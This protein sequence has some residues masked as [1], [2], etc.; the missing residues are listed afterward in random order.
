MI[1]T[2]PTRRMR[3][4]K[5]VILSGGSTTEI[6]EPLGPVK[7]TMLQSSVDEVRY[8]RI[9]SKVHCW[10]SKVSLAASR[11]EF[12]KI[13]ITE[14]YS[15]FLNATRGEEATVA[16]IRTAFRGTKR[17]NC[18]KAANS[19]VGFHSFPASLNSPPIPDCGS[20]KGVP[21]HA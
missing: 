18:E 3:A 1:Y 19:L 20:V 10:D 8:A 13:R 6:L 5:V 4:T 21:S 12:R 11:P 15:G 16:A 7:G 14:L 17:L 9:L 2:H